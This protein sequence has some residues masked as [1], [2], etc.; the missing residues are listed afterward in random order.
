MEFFFEFKFMLMSHKFNITIK[1]IKSILSNAPLVKSN[2]EIYGFI[3]L[4][5]LASLLVEKREEKKKKEV[6]TI[7]LL[8]L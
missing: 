3:L 8:K 6:R 5:V 1:L 7:S 4:S 2:I